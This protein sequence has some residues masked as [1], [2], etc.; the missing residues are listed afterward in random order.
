MKK[1]LVVDDSKTIR[2]LC[3]WIYKGLEDRILTADS[4]QT[5]QQMISSESPD[6]VIVDYTL[7]DR[8]AYDFVSSIRSKTHVVMM[9]GTYAPFSADKAKASGAVAVIMKPFKSQVFFDT[10]EEAFKADTSA[11]ASVETV[12]A[13]SDIIHESGVSATVSGSGLRSIP[14]I[15]SGLHTT[16]DVSSAVSPIVDAESSHS[17]S[18][19]HHIRPIEGKSGGV[20][21][22]SRN[23]ST[24]TSQTANAAKRFNFP[25]TSSAT[26]EP[27]PMATKSSEMRTADS[28]TPKTPVPSISPAASEGQQI[29][30]AVLRAEVIAAVKSM[31]PAIVNSYLKK[32]IQAEVKPQLQSW[33]DTRVE[34]L[35]KKK[36]Q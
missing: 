29:D 15:S 21:P 7:P 6:V 19:L 18:G 35:L 17:S 10:V 2:T 25:G 34:A 4:A 13:V 1:I 22:F 8:D 27:E 26:P 31:L 30:Q 11:V 33:V 28:A 12:S 14:K 32:L 24:G 23:A 36:D 9:G 5:A 16:S 20:A 3:E